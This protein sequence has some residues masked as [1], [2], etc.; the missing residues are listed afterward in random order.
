MPFYIG[1]GTG[2][3]AFDHL[4]KPDST[5]KYQRIKD[6]F[7]AGLRPIVDILVDNLSEAQALRIEAE[8][9]AAFG[10]IESGGLL[11]NSVIRGGLGG[12]K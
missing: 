2:T 1:K 3:K 10:T 9:I 8:L 11:T 5:R 4:V 12:K 7:D 6:I